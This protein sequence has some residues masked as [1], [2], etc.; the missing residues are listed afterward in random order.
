VNRRTALRVAAPLGAAAAALATLPASAAAHG[1]VQK[2]DIP[3][4]E[5][6]FAWAA[7]GV[8]IL[9]FIILAVFWPK[10]K[11][12]GDS[13]RPIGKGDPNGAQPAFW[14]VIDVFCGLIGVLLLI[15]VIWAGFDGVQTPAANIT[16]TFVYVIFWN[17]LVLFSILFGDLFRTF[18]PWRAAGIAVGWVAK[19]A[20]GDS[21][22]E[23]LKYPEKVG[24]YPAAL[25][26]TCFAA[27]ELVI[28]DGNLPRNV[29]I[30]TVLYSILT[31]IGMALYGVER[32]LD[33]GEAFNLYFNLFSRISPL[34]RR[35]GV[36]GVRKPLSGLTHV[37]MVPGTVAFVAVMIGGVT[38]DGFKEGPLFTSWTPHLSDFWHSLGFDLK[39]SLELAN[40]MG[41]IG[42]ILFIWGFY[43][44]GVK[45]AQSVGGGFDRETLARRFVHTL[46]PIAFVYVA[47]HYMTQL[48][49]QGQ[50][51]AYLGSDPLGRGWDLFGGRNSGIDFGVI[52]ATA[53]WYWQ[54]GFVVV[55]HVCAL[56]LAHDR[57]LILY[58]NARIAVRSQYWMLGI[59]VGFTSL[60]LW[61]LSQA[62]V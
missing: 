42:C 11:L 55:G 51:L 30:A 54:V 21:M 44:L 39:H 31:W 40:L 61:L 38:F 5:A 32:W 50:A 22:P 41:L 3:I 23:P 52:G 19:R 25:G 12:E 62:N 56:I 34:E 60:A 49:F 13:W 35:N 4:P 16:P 45:G 46:V 15:L 10:P 8:L 33:R 2:A 27:M 53:T 36:L 7:A 43:E 37:E 58:D 18:N 14:L 9:S 17:G 20:S 48:L 1:I 47:A 57:A 59:M 6:V 28:D 26:L 29:A 24:R